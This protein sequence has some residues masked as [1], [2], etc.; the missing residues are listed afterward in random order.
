M[1]IY[2]SVPFDNDSSEADANL[3]P[4]Y[5]RALQT[6][7]RDKELDL[8][9]LNHDQA[10]GDQGEAIKLAVEYM[11]EAD[12]ICFCPYYNDGRRC[13]RS[14]IECNIAATIYPD[15]EINTTMMQNILADYR[16]RPTVTTSLIKERIR[17]VPEDTLVYVRVGN[18]DL[19]V[20]KIIDEP[21]K[22]GLSR[23]VMVT[24]PGEKKSK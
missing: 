10:T 13:D 11:N 17:D 2:L 18:N 22:S 5:I 7:Y 9:Y 8:L 6:Y 16:Q 14:E 23:I 12:L 21:F 20:A 15:K 3:I 1:K 24:R 4:N 19:S